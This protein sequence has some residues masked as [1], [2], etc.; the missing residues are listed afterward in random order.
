MSMHLYSLSA[1]LISNISIVIRCNTP[2]TRDNTSLFD[3]EI[4]SICDL[5]VEALQKS[6]LN[7]LGT[8]KACQ[9][10]CRASPKAHVNSQAAQG[11]LYAAPFRHL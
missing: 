5:K 7:I 10:T 2:N 6:N 9:E 8:N 1:I 4:S 11:R 3:K